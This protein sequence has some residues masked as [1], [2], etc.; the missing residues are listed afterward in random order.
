MIVPKIRHHGAVRGVAGSCHQLYADAANSYLIDSGLFRGAET[1]RSGKAGQGSLNIESPLDTVQAV[2][3]THV[4]I[5]HVG[6]AYL[7]AAGFKGPILCSEPSD[8]LLPIVLKDAFKLGVNGDQKQVKRYI[9]L[10]EQ[11]IFAFLYQTWFTL[12]DS[13]SMHCRVRQRRADHIL[14]SAYV[15]FD[16]TYPATN[17]NKRIVFSGDLGAPHAPLLRPQV[18]PERV[19]ILVLESAYGDRLHEDRQT[20]RQRP[21]AVLSRHSAGQG[22]RRDSCIQHRPH[23]GAALR[24]RRHHP[25]QTQHRCLRRDEHAREPSYRYRATPSPPL[26]IAGERGEATN[27]ILEANAATQPAPEASRPELQ[28]SST[29]PPPP[30]VSL[31]HIGS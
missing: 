10:I 20:G 1:S 11:G 6:T 13:P 27:E 25:N 2:I 16:L 12:H 7:L 14:G 31:L 15:D 30:A 22:H 3:A 17:T 26:E 29:L 4:H 24:T 21:E 28:S 18:S 23:P 5:D 8:E 19:D 9:N